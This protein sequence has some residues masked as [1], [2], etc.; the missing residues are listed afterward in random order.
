[1]RFLYEL[2]LLARAAPALADRYRNQWL[3]V[4]ISGAIA[5][6]TKILGN[7]WFK[8]DPEAKQVL[9]RASQITAIITAVATGWAF[10]ALVM[11]RFPL[12]ELVC[13]EVK[14]DAHYYPPNVRAYDVIEISKCINRTD[15]PIRQFA[16]FKDGYWTA[17]DSWNATAQLIAAESHT[18]ARVETPAAPTHEVRELP[19]G[20]TIHW[21]Q[22]TAAFNPSLAPGDY[23]TVECKIEARGAVETEAF[24]IAGTEYARGVNF[25]TLVYKIAIHAPAGYKVVFQDAR[26]LNA[27]HENDDSETKR[28]RKAKL[29]KDLTLLTWRIT[30][31]REPFRYSLRYRFEPTA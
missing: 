25:N 30:L 20:K 29:S 17:L 10:I 3:I 28:Q 6:A 4:I 22:R 26:V 15:G 27:D 31:A 13:R 2:Y 21:Y 24:T 18:I 5:I 19:G 1:M 16:T 14:V 23:C 9:D 8:D 11:T 7:G 12:D